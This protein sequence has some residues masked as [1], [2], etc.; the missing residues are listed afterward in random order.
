MVEVLGLLGSHA[1]SAAD[2][3]VSS[4]AIDQLKASMKA[5]HVKLSKYYRAG[6]IGY[7]ADGLV[8]ARDLSKVGLRERGTW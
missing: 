4:P 5:R 3:N 6:A 1:Q 8:A 7:S 2:M